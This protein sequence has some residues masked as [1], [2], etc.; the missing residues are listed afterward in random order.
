MRKDIESDRHLTLQS[1]DGKAVFQIINGRKEHLNMQDKFFCIAD[2]I[3]ILPVANM[4]EHVRDTGSGRLL[5]G[6]KDTVAW[7]NG[8]R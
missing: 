7:H 6:R 5:K 1:P 3:E 4:F 2:C 8:L